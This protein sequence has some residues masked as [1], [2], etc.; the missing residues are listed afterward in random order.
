MI[1][2]IILF[3]DQYYEFI[4]R[5]RMLNIILMSFSL[6]SI[7]LFRPA[8]TFLILGI[9]FTSLLFSQ[10]RSRGIVILIPLLLI[11]LYFTYGYVEIILNRFIGIGGLTSMLENK[12]AS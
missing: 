6:L 8:V 11:F 2:L 5:K 1:F 7:V 3:Y 10:R 9:V 4:T 12:E